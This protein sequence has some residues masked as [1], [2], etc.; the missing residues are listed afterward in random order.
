MIGEEVL[1]E[2]DVLRVVRLRGGGIDALASAI[3]YVQ[4]AIRDG[5]ALHSLGGSGGVLG[6]GVVTIR[7]TRQAASE[8]EQAT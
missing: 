4:G 8:K 3:P 1:E 5:W 6:M 7:L 2:T